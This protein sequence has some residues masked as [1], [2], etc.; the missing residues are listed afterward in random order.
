MKCKFSLGV[1][2]IVSVLSLF[3]SCTNL[4][5]KENQEES[6]NQD[7]VIQLYDETSQNSSS[8]ARVIRPFSS[9][10]V[11]LVSVWNISFTDLSD[12][13]N[14]FSLSTADPASGTKSYATLSDSTVALKRIPKST[15]KIEIEGS[16]TKDS[17]TAAFYGTLPSV[18]VGSGVSSV[19][20]PVGLKKNGTCSLSLT[21]TD[22]ASALANC[23]SKIKLNL[24]SVTG[25]GTYDFE[26]SDSSSDSSSSSEF[27]Y[28]STDNTFTLTKSEIPSGY[29]RVSFSYDAESSVSG[30]KV[31][32]PQQY[33]TVEV[34]DGVETKNSST[35]PLSIAYEKNYYATNSSSAAKK[36]GLTVASKKYLKSLL[37][38]IA[39]DID[40]LEESSINIYMGKEIPEIDADTYSSFINAIKESKKS[41]I[42]G[43]YG[44]G[45]TEMSSLT[46]MN[47]PS[48]SSSADSGQS[49]TSDINYS[50]VLTA[51]ESSS[52]F[53]VN[54]LT[55]TSG[56]PF[57]LTF[58]NGAKLVAGDDETS[59]LNAKITIDAVK[60]NS[61]GSTEANYAAYLLADSSPLFECVWKDSDSS[62]ITPCTTSFV[63][64][65]SD[66]CYELIDKTESG[67]CKTYFQVAE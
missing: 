1:V 37:T 31:S 49:L 16:F 46:I 7:F 41:L 18:A 9:A 67:T 29:Y 33:S 53:N 5:E 19:L 11:S 3:F 52:V 25:T 59:L 61:D 45:Q 62:K 48:D 13:S 44:A 38:S 42:L 20:I 4:Q 17:S 54:T 40:S 43:I 55:A 15:Y 66:C 50:I 6:E 10:E 26:A 36:N 64:N 32:I 57:S 63:L 39:A 8:S 56:S 14:N 2:F 58:K 35:I 24:K 60:E 30:F 22:S 21:F 47:V 34:V 51:G 23:Y 28:S 27:V 65:D 12:S